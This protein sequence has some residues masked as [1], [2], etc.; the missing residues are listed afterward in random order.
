MVSPSYS[1]AILVP[2]LWKFL[3]KLLI[4][5]PCDL[6]IPLLGI[7]LEETKIERDTSITLFIATLFAIA[8]TWRQPRCPL[9]DETIEKLWYINAME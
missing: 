8:I 4:K 7:Y 9:T 6:A 3:K 2:S 1:S 5:P